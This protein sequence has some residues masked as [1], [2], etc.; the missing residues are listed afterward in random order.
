MAGQKWLW[1]LLARPLRSLSIV[2]RNA[3]L[4]ICHEPL[5]QSATSNLQTGVCG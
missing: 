5:S 3:S 4:K 2:R 1:E